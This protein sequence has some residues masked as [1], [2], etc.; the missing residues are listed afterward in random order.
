MTEKS[1]AAIIGENILDMDAIQRHKI[2]PYYDRSIPDSEGEW[3]RTDD[4]LA[5]RCRLLGIGQQAM[6]ESNELYYFRWM[7]EMR[8]NVVE[9]ASWVEADGFARTLTG[10]KSE[11]VPRHWMRSERLMREMTIRL[12]KN[13]QLRSDERWILI[14]SEW[15][16]INANGRKTV[17]RDE[18]YYW[19]VEM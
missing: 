9:T 3:M 19:T 2:P 14:D 1:L 5:V 18:S 6:D 16:R 15:P 7:V 13:T 12:M 8:L 10:K 4:V 17:N 11:A